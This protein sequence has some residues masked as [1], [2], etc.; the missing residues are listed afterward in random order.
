MLRPFYNRDSIVHRQNGIEFTMHQDNRGY[1]N[2]VSKLLRSVGNLPNSL[3]KIKKVSATYREWTLL[4]KTLGAILT[5]SDLTAYFTESSINF[6]D[7]EYIEQIFSNN[8]IDSVRGIF[9]FLLAAIDFDLTEESKVVVIREGYDGALDEMRRVLDSLPVELNQAAH[10]ILE[11]CPLLQN[12]TVEYIPQFGYMS[13]V[14]PAEAMF[15]DE[16]DFSFKYQDDKCYYKCAV[17]EALD[18]RIG[19]IKNSILDYQKQMMVVI[20]ETVL[21][22]ETEL[23]AVSYALGEIDALIALGEVALERQYVRPEIETQNVLVIKNGRHPLQEMT[24]LESFIANDTCI[25]PDKNIALITGANGSGKTVYIKQV[26]LIVYMAHIGM[27]VPC[28]KAVIGLTDRIMTRIASTESV[29]SSQSSFTLDLNQISSMLNTHTDRSL[30]LIDE[31][32]KG[33]SPVDGIALLSVTISHFAAHKAMAFFVLHFTEALDPEIFPSES[34]ECVTLFNMA[35]HESSDFDEKESLSMPLYKLKLGIGASSEGI[36]CA[37]LAG[38]P[39]TVLDRAFE[40][41]T[42]IQTRSFL[43]P[44]DDVRLKDIRDPLYR[45][46]LVTGLLTTDWKK[47]SDETIVAFKSLI[48]SM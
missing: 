5:I 2:D 15:L 44:L 29:V 4:H 21:D 34:M 10:A 32:G 39:T 12:V 47:A 27:L 37:R 11:Q 26:G 41:K 19:D 1:I 48:D 13:A 24:S 6:E 31:F 8:D 38:I 46:L 28:D 30:C 40:I 22:K 42:A 18:D 7:K 16:Q 23:I 14:D 3:L 20:E 25:L 36:P 17:V 9:N 45:E 33:T 43:N 35:C